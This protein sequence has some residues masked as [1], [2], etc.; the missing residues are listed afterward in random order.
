MCGIVAALSQGGAIPVDALNRAVAALWHRGPDGQRTWVDP[1]GRVALGHA[2]LSIID[3]ATGEQPIANEDERAWIVANGEFYDY[4]RVQTELER[5]GRHRLRTRSDSE[6]ALHL[7]E[8]LGVQSVHRLRGEY[9]FAIWDDRA[10]KLFAVRDRYGVKPLFYAKHAGVLYLASEMKALFA[11]GV[12]A[13]W[14]PEGVYFGT[15]LRA[16][17]KTPFLG[18]YSVP[19]GH[20]LMADRDGERL[21]QYWDIDYPEGASATPPA[22]DREYVEGF[23]AEIDEAVRIRLRADVPVGCYLSGGIDSCAVLGLAARHASTPIRAFTLRFD[24]ADYDEGE[25][26][27]AMAEKAGA[28]WVPIPI[29]QELLA[30]HFADALFHGEALCVN[31]H[32]VAK[33]LLSRAVRDAG[34]KVVL[35]GEGSDEVL[36]GYPHFRMDMLRYDNAGQDAAETER[37]RKGLEEGNRVSRGILLGDDATSFSPLMQRLLGFTPSMYS[38]IVERQAR[39]SKCYRP[40]Y[41]AAYD[42]VD[43]AR[44]ILDAFDVKRR[45]NGRAPVHQSLYLWGKTI[46]PDYILTLLGDRMEMAHSVEGRVPFLDHHVGEFLARVPVNMKIR[47]L[48]EKYVLREA[49]RDVLT[50]TV[51]KRQKHPFLSPPESAGKS[52]RMSELVHDTLTSNAVASVPFLDA[53]AVREF[54]TTLDRR[55]PEDRAMLDT[56]VMLLMSTVVLHQRFGVASA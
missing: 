29:T 39:L 3:L 53:R 25:I 6:I 9:A 14:D 4:E 35:T 31:S 47:G 43:R 48:T 41:L 7:Y 2:R 37:L 1:R 8:D 32:F 52:S 13:R 40:D 54:V 36:G 38:S 5:S 28:E 46:L 42:G 45:L 19:A 27:Q 26:A 15:G 23:R 50:D 10:Q 55:A 12:P 18:V 33:Y 34:Y 24:H 11:A 22:D 51:Y 16:P 20:Y 56:D 49:T 17:N 44:A 30:D 21:A